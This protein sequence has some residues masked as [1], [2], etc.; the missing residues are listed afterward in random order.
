[1]LNLLLSQYSRTLILAVILLLVLV[2]EMFDFRAA[3]YPDLLPFFEWLKNST[4]LGI[5]G[6]TYG[7]IY[8]TIEAIHLISMAVIGGT[9]LTA[10][11]RLLGLIFKDVPSESLTK[12]THRVFSIALAAAIATGVF[13]AAGV[14]DK[15]YYMEVFWIKMLTLV[16]GSLYMFFVKQPLLNSVPHSEI[17][18]WTVRLLAITSLLIWFTVAATG[19]WIGFS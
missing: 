1:M 11:L 16:A 13:C 8:A 14:G 3:I 5:I 2:L 10:D 6:T 17:N 12:G 15:V 18:P 9:V 7:S 19:R 4:W